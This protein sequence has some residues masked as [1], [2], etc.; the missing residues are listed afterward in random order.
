M[1]SSMNENIV[2]YII[3]LLQTKGADI[4][5]GN[6]DVTQLEHALQCAELAEQ[7]KLSNATITAALLHDIG[8]LLYENDDPI[9]EGKDGYHENLGA[10]YLSKYFK[11]NV[12][13]PIRAH[14]DSKRYLSKVEEGYYESL[15]EASKLSLKVQGGPF[16]E[17]EA[18]KFIQK[19]FMKEAVEMRRFDDLAKVLNKKTQDLNHFRHYLDEEHQSYLKK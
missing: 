3:N 9:H 17:E 4:Q 18:E 10:D 11:E 14:V 2:S 1:K 6:E 19:P 16:S 7:H 13:I 5:Y 15:S 8:H 12:T